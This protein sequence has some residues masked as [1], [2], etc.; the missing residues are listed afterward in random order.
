MAHIVEAVVF[1][2]GQGRIAFD[3]SSWPFGLI[4]K[5]IYMCVYINIDVSLLLYVNPGI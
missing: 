4:S 3:A 1:G 2:H 5:Y